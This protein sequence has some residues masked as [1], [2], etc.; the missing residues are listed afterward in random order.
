[1]DLF[2]MT[3][4]NNQDL[5]GNSSLR[6]SLLPL[7]P[8]L[9][10]GFIMMLGNGLINILLPV[11]M[12]LDA[13]SADVIGLVLS[14]YFVGMLLGGLYAKYL[15]I[16][17]GH[18]RMFAGCLALAAVSILV[19]GLYTD[20][21]LWGGMRIVIGFCNACAFTATE[22]WLTESSS[23]ENRGKVL[24]LYQAIILVAMFFGQFFIGLADPQSTSLFIIAGILLS[25]AVI[26]V[27]F[28]RSSG[29]VL[30][31]VVSMS[32][33]ALMKISPLGVISIFI[34]GI[35]Y[36]SAFNML[37]IMAAYYEIADFQLSLFMGTAILGGFVLQ[38]PVGYISDRFD[39][40]TVLLSLLSISVITGLSINFLAN[41]HHIVA[42]FAATGI[43]CGIIACTYPLSISEALEQVKQRE[44]V[45]AMGSLILVFSAGGILGPYST[46]LFMGIFG[47]ASLFWYL[48]IVQIVLIL[49]V[50]RSINM[51]KT[52]PT[53]QQENFVMHSAALATLTDLDPRA[54][55]IEPEYPL[56]DVALFASQIAD[57][58]PAM[59]VKIAQEIATSSSEQSSE[60]IGAIAMVDGINVKKLYKALLNSVPEKVTEFTLAIV[61]A[62]PEVA[63]EVMSLLAELK[64]EKLASVAQV[65][66]DSVPETRL[67]MAKIVVEIEPESA[68]DVVDHYA[69][70]LSEEHDN[71][72]HADR[73]EDS[74]EQDAIDLYSQIS[75]I[76]PEQSLELAV[77]VVDAMHY[78]ATSVA[79]AYAEGLTEG[80]ESKEGDELGLEVVEITSRLAEVAPEY[81]M[82]IGGAVIEAQPEFASEIIDS[83][84]EGEES[85]ES[86]LSLSIAEHEK[87]P[88]GY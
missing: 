62:Q 50:I 77:T 36:S 65:I 59:A 78:S 7:L 81:S 30:N 55:Y 38:F 27:V 86:E 53:K 2:F 12:G 28:S 72:R 34:S 9:L 54:Q 47:E 80:D 56:S 76:V 39:R 11:R 8:L 67:D 64:P 20:T 24:A 51:V 79:T 45:S 37:P 33:V 69:N 52:L 18:I 57:T 87:N 49:F 88:T 4:T 85:E 23:K 35:I 5:V 84:S 63:Y 25:A 60:V 82:D 70:V 29:P 66:G 48:A 3:S 10:S 16:R 43:T 19:C 22:S 6:S 41:Q 26:P 31:D 21:L 58:Q 14:L 73:S 17:A 13:L 46:S 74:T 42:M 75:E 1:L 68:V 44:I 71:V 32:L 83:L 15:I 40:R 61:A